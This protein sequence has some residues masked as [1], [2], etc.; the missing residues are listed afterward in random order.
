MA[1][2]DK[3]ALTLAVLFTGTLLGFSCRQN[4]RGI[5]SV[6]DSRPR[7]DNYVR[8]EPLLPIDVAGINMFGRES[9]TDFDRAIAFDSQDRLYILDTYTSQISVFDID[10]RFVRAFGRPGQGPEE[11]TSPH[12]IVIK[13]DRIYVFEGFTGLKILSLDGA[14]IS[15]GVV[16]IENLL[17]LRAVDDGFYL[18]RAKTDPTFTKLTFLLSKEGEDFAGGPKLFECD[19]TP[20]LRGPNYNFGWHDWMLI[21]EDGKFFFPEDNFSRYLI[22]RYDAAGR[23]ELRFGRTYKALEYSQGARAR[24]E[25]LFE[26]WIRTGEM[27]FPPSPPIVGNMFQ[28]EKRNVW[29]IAGESSEDNGNTEF[30]NTIDIFS[31]KGEWLSSMKSKTLSR[32][33]HYHGGRI[34]KIP[35]PDADRPGQVIEV[36]RIR[37]LDP[38]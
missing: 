12:R 27:K 15:K 25:A 1:L 6:V 23:P 36:F 31:R 35:S 26:R 14:Y 2:K 30:E 3:T 24:F 11:F 34:Y 29:V 18:F 5:T 37:Y 19:Y 10:G 28:D 13:D 8:L 9:A 22:T 20:G 16:N 17:K 21:T 4:E 32:F 33:C 7:F 38:R